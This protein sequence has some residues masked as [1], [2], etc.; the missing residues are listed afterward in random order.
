MIRFGEKHLIL[1]KTDDQVHRNGQG[2]DQ[3]QGDEIGRDHGDIPAEGAQHPEHGDYR[4][5]T[6]EH[7]QDDP[8]SAAEKQTEH[9]YQHQ[10]DA[11]AEDAQIVLDVGDHII[12]DHADPAEIELSAVAVSIHD[13][14]YGLD[15]LVL[16]G[17]EHDLPGPYLGN[18]AGVFL[19][20]RGRELA[21]HFLVEQLVSGDDQFAVI[22]VGLEVD[23][24][25]RGPGIPAHQQVPVKGTAGQFLEGQIFIHPG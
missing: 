4:Q 18:Q 23:D 11:E 13:A 22:G 10:K 20:F 24:D 3:L 15:I 19:R 2:D 17:I 7:R 5:K 6:A 14:P 8:A 12:G 21:V 16:L 9:Q 25:G 1:A